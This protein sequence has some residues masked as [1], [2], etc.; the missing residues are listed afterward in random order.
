MQL[1]FSKFKFC[2]K[3]TP[4]HF[5]RY[6]IISK[7]PYSDKNS[8]NGNSMRYQIIHSKENETNGERMFI[9]VLNNEYLLT[10]EKIPF[11][12]E[13]E[14]DAE[15]ELISEKEYFPISEDTLDLYKKWT[16]YYVYNQI[17]TY[18]KQNRNAYDYR[19]ENQYSQIITLPNNSLQITIKRIFRVNTEVMLDGT[20]FLA[21]DIKCEFESALT[22]Y[23]FIQMQ[24]D[25]RGLSVKCIWQGFDKTYQ[26][27]MVHDTPISK[28]IDGIN[29]YDYWNSQKPHLLKGLDL[30]APAVSALDEKKKRSGLYIPQSLKPVITREY[31]AVHDK[32]LSAQVDQFTKL[33]MKKRLEIIRSFLDAINSSRQIVDTAPVPVS[34]FCYQEMSLEKDLPSL[35]IANGRK[36]KFSE[37]YKAFTQGFYKLPEQPILAAFMSYDEEAQKSYDVVS[38]ILDYTRGKVN[39]VQDRY[40]N[41]NLLPLGFYGKSFHYKKG[42]RLS[43]EE[44][45]REISKI[46]GINFA[47]AALPLEF[48]EEDY[49]D[50]SVASPYDSFKKVFADLGIPS[51]MVSLSMVKDLGSNNIKY[52]LQNLILGILCKSGGI[53]WVLESPMDGVDCFIGLDVGTQ[54]KGIHYPAC[55]VCLD[56][57]GNLVGYYSTNVAQRGEIIDVKSLETIFNSV[58]T[59]YKEAN[60]CYPKHIVIHRDGFSHEESDWYDSYFARRDI[61]FDVVEVRKNIPLRLM[62]T[63]AVND[64]MN[65]ASGSA[66]I[67]DNEAY[68]ISTAV[69]PYLGAPR[70]LLLVHRK[71]E[72]S[73]E[74][75]VRQIYV[76]SEMHIGS[77]RTSRLP[78]TTLYADKICKHHVHV[79]HDTLSNK[80]FFI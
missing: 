40:V 57:R 7:N 67:K 19:I 70:P 17:V 52:R 80:L 72:L 49:Y 47:I 20:V 63:E 75:I 25:V 51:Q 24:K 21:V 6:R 77:M 76:L 48:D 71:G 18:C 74:S 69:K 78:L 60:G 35:L 23:D 16:E 43:Y 9:Y 55:S 5:Y 44:T 28:S 12:P 46:S 32:T 22:I 68:L 38:S 37:K 31:I 73:I 11:I 61:K 54:E 53:P 59:A 29:L 41:S 33:S 79:P 15:L 4:K 13:F 27:E 3:T 30:N 56:G 58:L 26:I 50:D 45:A 39:H 10:Y 64:E 8:F 14:N 42:D 2:K 36:I 34:E 1:C 66:I 62:D 65:P